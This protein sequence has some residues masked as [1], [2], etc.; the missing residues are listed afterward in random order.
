MEQATEIRIDKYLWAVRLYKT[1]SLATEACQK[2]KVLL[3]DQLTKPSRTVKKNDLISIKMPP[4]IKTYKI[5]KLAKNRMGAKLVI[6]HIED[7][8]P[9][10]Q[11]EILE[12]AKMA[13]SMGRRKGTGR[14]TKKERRDL[15]E[16]LDGDWE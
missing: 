6:E 2:G 12:M 9:Q 7:I 16:L 11:I 5:I 8:T 15:E 10:G 14:P 13:S 3:N 1:R 4:I